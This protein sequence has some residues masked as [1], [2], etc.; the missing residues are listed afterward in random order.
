M[1]QLYISKQPA[2]STW[3]TDRAQALPLLRALSEAQPL[4]CGEAEEAAYLGYIIAVAAQ[5]RGQ[6]ASWAE[7][8][9]AG[10]AALVRHFTY[11]A[12]RPEGVG[13]FLAWA[14]RQGI[15]QAL[16]EK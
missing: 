14:V 9:T 4:A 13:R 12:G 5:Y 10:H 3:E 11:Y 6:G 16:P 1:R 7:L 15:L 2:D 8:L